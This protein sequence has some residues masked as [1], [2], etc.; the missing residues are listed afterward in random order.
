MMGA[1]DLSAGLDRAVS[2]LTGPNSTA[3]SNK[4]VILL[5]DGEWNFGRHPLEAARDARDAGV[6][7]HCVLML[8]TDQPVI[9][10]V[11]QITGG[12]YYVTNNESELRQA[13]HELA[14]SLPVVMTQ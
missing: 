7:V 9:R 4:V 1:T 5:T 11:A 3:F 14:R 2:V 6:I 13:F 10:Q 12:R 8:T